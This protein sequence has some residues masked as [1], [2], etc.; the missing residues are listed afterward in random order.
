MKQITNIISMLLLVLC[1]AACGK[2]GTKP[3]P[4]QQTFSGKL[5]KVDLGNGMYDSLFYREDGKLNKII[6]FSPT[7]GATYKEVFHFAYNSM[8]KVSSVQI[9]NGDEYRYTYVNNNIAAVS[10]F[11]NGVKMNYK[12]INYDGEGTKVESVEDYEKTSPGAAGF[13]YTFKQEYT[14]YSNGNLKE[15]IRY[16]INPNG[17]AIKYQTTRYEDYDQHVNVDNVFRHFIYLSG[18]SFAANNPRKIIRRD[19]I[20]GSEQ[21]YNYQFTYNETHTPLKRTMTTGN[22]TTETE[23]TYSY[24]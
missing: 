2:S 6:M 3:H 17:Q 22:G 15:E 16:Q 7:G 10:H 20:T 24:Y 5:A 13:A 12:F 21:Q 18:V 9:E 14:Y 11:E 8:G 19:E 23:I 4:V 1:L